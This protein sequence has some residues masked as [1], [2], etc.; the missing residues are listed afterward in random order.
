LGVV[1]AVGAAL[2]CLDGVVEPLELLHVPK[3]IAAALAYRNVALGPARSRELLEN[4]VEMAHWEST[5]LSTLPSHGRQQLLIQLYH[6]Y[7]GVHWKNQVDAHRLH[8]E[9]FLTWA[10]SG[11]VD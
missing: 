8:L 2:H 6:E 4:A 5:Q 9:Q 1:H 7:L 3:E 10:C 11:R